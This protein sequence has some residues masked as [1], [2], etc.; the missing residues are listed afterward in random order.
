MEKMGR[1]ILHSDMNCYY[2]S[3]EIMQHPELR[4]KP[5][6]VCGAVEDRHGIV[7][8]K[9][10]EAKRMGVRTGMASWEARVFCPDLIIVSPHY[11]LYFKF[12]RFARHIYQQYSDE[13]EPFGLDEC[14]IDVTRS[15]IYGDGVEIAEKIRKEIREKLGLTVSIGVSWNKVFAK[16]GSDMKKPDAITIITPQNYREN[17]WPLP[18]SDLLYV[19]P[20]TTR[21]LN[22]YGIHTIGDLAQR[23]DSFMKRL[24]GK[25][26][27][28]IR[29]FA[30]GLDRSP[31]RPVDAKV[32]VHSVGKGITCTGDL[33]EKEEVSRVI[34]ALAQDVGTR[35]RKLHAFASGIHLQLRMADL[36]FWQS[37]CRLE[38]PVY[39]SPFLADAIIRHLLSQFPWQ[40][41]IRA[42]S[43]RTDRLIP[44]YVP[45]PI[46]LFRPQDAAMGEK[47]E[48]LDTAIDEIRRRFGKDAIRPACLLN[49]LKMPD[50]GRDE[51]R[52]PGLMYR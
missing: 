14:W 33:H 6:A 38:T 3:V 21:K 30:A 10:Y 16:L 44:D 41:P 23:P 2:A 4:G 34:I 17:V 5:V 15:E 27:V 8:A 11:D 51:I 47:I 36:T 28:M 26:G 35:L 32:P 19:G 37:Q 52:L 1:T 29:Q 39:S 50:D 45:R 9:S 31:V 24:I 7:L 12:S 49:D 40:R 18:V 22:G 20:A 43:I 13:V 42:V 46:N 48:K 25:N